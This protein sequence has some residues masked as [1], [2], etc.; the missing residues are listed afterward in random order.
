MKLVGK[1][2][3]S[4]LL[5]RRGEMTKLVPSPIFVGALAIW[6]NGGYACGARAAFSKTATRCS[7]KES[8][9]L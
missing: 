9:L 5:H 2:S 4:E 7:G 8:S 6:H 1:R 3:L